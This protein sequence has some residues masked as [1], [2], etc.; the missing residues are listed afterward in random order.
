MDP[1]QLRG[2]MTVVALV[3]YLGVVW[4]AYRTR[5]RDRFERDA[6]LPF[7]DDAMPTADAVPPSAC[8]GARGPQR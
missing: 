2:L 8:D 6:L 5:N 1:G 3:A 4:W 7:A